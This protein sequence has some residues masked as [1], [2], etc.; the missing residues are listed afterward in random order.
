MYM[1]TDK[2]M[3][4]L[5]DRAIEI[6]LQKNPRLRQRRIH[7]ELSLLEHQRKEIVIPSIIFK[8][9]HCSLPH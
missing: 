8:K 7:I 5:E 9:F 4:I 2:D 6:H 3:T 1:Q